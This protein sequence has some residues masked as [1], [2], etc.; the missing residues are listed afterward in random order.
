MAY[1]EEGE[2]SIWL[3]SCCW[4]EGQW[5]LTDKLLPVESTQVSRQGSPTGRMAQQH[6]SVPPNGGRC[7]AGLTAEPA[8]D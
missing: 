1:Q 6:V 5:H 4:Y 3:T 7:L 2:S 8:M